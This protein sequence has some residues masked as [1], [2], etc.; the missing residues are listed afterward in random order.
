MTLLQDGRVLVVS[1]RDGAR[2]FDPGTTQWQT[3]PSMENNPYRH[4]AVALKDG[5]VLIVGGSYLYDPD[6]TEMKR[7]AGPAIPRVFHT[8]TLLDD[9]RILVAGGANGERS[10]E[11]FD[12]VAGQWSDAARLNVGRGFHSAVRL[13]DGAVMVVG[14]R[15]R[16]NQRVVVIEVYDAGENKWSRKYHTPEDVAGYPVTLAD[17]RVLF[18][19]SETWVYES[20]SEDW[21]NVAGPPGREFGYSITSLSDGR[22]LVLG[23]ANR[24]GTT[25]PPRLT[26]SASIFDPSTN[27]WLEAP[28]LRA[29]RSWHEAV[30]LPDGRVLVIGGSGGEIDVPETEFYAVRPR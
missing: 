18:I 16:D 10:A 27:E 25:T 26:A 13:P 24:T 29:S 15:D 7:I 5:R 3:V 23:G 28:P 2:L 22:V 21:S 6:V 20:A 30:E 4:E 14:G 12:P 8:L 1:W 9:G 11:I 17:G 19:G